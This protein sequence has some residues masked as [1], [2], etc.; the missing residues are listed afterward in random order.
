[1]TAP[2]AIEEPEQAQ[3]LAW[4]AACAT[5]LNIARATWRSMRDQL[6]RG[7]GRKA[8]LLPAIA[9]TGAFLAGA[10]FIASRRS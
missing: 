3:L 8:F 7:R 9:I 10:W 6:P 2:T 5:T 1:M 4:A